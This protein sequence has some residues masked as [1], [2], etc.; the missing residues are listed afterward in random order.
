MQFTLMQSKSGAQKGTP[1][2]SLQVRDWSCTSAT[3]SVPEKRMDGEKK[4]LGT[5]MSE[6]K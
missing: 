1:S 5:T 4:N 6:G 3:L 2:L